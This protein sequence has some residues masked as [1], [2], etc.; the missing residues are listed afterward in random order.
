M[1][2]LRLVIAGLAGRFLINSYII[3]FRIV[4]GS[5]EWYAILLLNLSHVLSTIHMCCQL[6]ICVVDLSHVLSTFHMCC[7]PFES[8]VNLS[9]VLSTFHMC[10]QPFT[11]VVNLSNVLSTFHMSC[12]PFTCIVNLSHVLS[13][14]HMCCHVNLSRLCMKLV[15]KFLARE[16]FPIL[17]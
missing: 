6:F 1:S 11:C 17:C 13:T 10:C 12:Q 3:D 14:F 16:Y 4:L 9:H 8:L 2:A 15:S 7:Q 5:E